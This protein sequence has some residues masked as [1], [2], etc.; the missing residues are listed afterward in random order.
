MSF[1]VPQLDRR[2][3]HGADLTLIKILITHSWEDPLLAVIN[4]GFLMNSGEHKHAGASTLM[5]S[6]RLLPW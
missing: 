6:Y 3:M 4:E 2:Y 5:L 1:V